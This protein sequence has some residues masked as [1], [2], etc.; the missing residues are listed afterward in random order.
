MNLTQNGT[1]VTGSGTAAD[2]ADPPPGIFTVNGSVNGSNITL[3]IQIQPQQYNG[4]TIDVGKLPIQFSGTLAAT[5]MTGTL[6]GGGLTGSLAV[7]FNK[8]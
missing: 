4:Q 5:S 2:P 1:G 8:Q 6:S 7:T 3:T